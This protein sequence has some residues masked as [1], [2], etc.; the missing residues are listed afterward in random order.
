MENVFFKNMYDAAMFLSKMVCE[1]C[2]VT[3]DLKELIDSF[4]VMSFMFELLKKKKTNAKILLMLEKKCIGIACY[5][6][7]K[8]VEDFDESEQL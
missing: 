8:I 1:R 7:D 6:W 4:L 2:E 5:L 3:E